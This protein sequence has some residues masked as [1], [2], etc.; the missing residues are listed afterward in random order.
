[1]LSAEVQEG[2]LK[3]IAT[4]LAC[5][6][7]NM[8]GSRCDPLI[9]GECLVILQITGIQ[10]LT[11][12]CIPDLKQRM[13]SNFTHAYFGRLSAIDLNLDAFYPLL[14]YDGICGLKYVSRE[15]VEFLLALS[16]KSEDAELTTTGVKYCFKSETTYLRDIDLVAY[17][18]IPTF[19]KP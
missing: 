17:P 14:K 15:G 6:T 5:C 13:I 7:R 12:D 1:M 8:L 11:S 18:F 2:V 10:S 9:V 3:H 4:D 16:Y 19:Y